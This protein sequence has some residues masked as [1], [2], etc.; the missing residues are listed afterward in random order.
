M[1]KPIPFRSPKA[2]LAAFA[3]GVFF[4]TVPGPV[5]AA[6]KGQS[7]WSDKAKSQVRLI[8]SHLD[9]GG[10][11]G[12]YAGVQLRMDAGWKTY[13]RNPGD[14]GVP[15]RFDWSGSTNVKS[16]RV[17]Y[18]A[19]HR[20]ADASGTA[21]GYH[22][23]VVFPVKIV[24][25]E[26]AE[27]VVLSLAFDYGLCKDLCIPNAVELEVM[28]PPDL[29]KGDAAL[30]R[31]ALARVPKPATPDTLPR[32]AE[33]AESLEGEHPGLTLE[34]AFPDGAKDTDVFID[35]PM[36]LIPV[37]KALGPVED[38][39]QRFAVAFTTPQEARAIKG[40][41]L[42]ITVVSDRGASQ[43]RWTAD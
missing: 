21:I 14:S 9:Q 13:W 31:T 25:E 38:G 15:P 33:V 27:P 6:S 40:R 11:V 34:A 16:I 18:P 24:P 43:T 28:I 20:F 17:L 5:V 19:P 3:V 22:D 39:R 36:V 4:A 35:N 10:Q 1:H 30:I 23:E 41:P 12:L 8:S 7:D 2:L 26:I 37:P 32:I 42:T 29:G